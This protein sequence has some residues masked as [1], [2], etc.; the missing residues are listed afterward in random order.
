MGLVNTGGQLAGFV[1]PLAIGFI[2]EAFNGSFNAAFWMLIVFAFICA[3]ALLTI[4]YGKDAL[5]TKKNEEV[6]AS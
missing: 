2:V 1:T 5:L 3:I 6:S 4:S